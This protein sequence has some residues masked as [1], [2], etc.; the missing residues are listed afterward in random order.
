[1]VLDDVS[2]GVSDC[3]DTGDDTVQ[4]KDGTTMSDMLDNVVQ[5]PVIIPCAWIIP[6]IRC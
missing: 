5:L 2:G 3:S 1:M 4:G 6:A